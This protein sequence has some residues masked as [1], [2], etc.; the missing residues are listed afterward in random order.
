MP[1]SGVLLEELRDRGRFA[2]RLE[3][4]DLGIRQ[5]DEYDRH[6]M[7]RLRQWGSDL[8]AERIAV[9]GRCLVQILDRYGHVVQASD[10]Q[11]SPLAATGVFR[12]GSRAAPVPFS[13]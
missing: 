1:P 12:N 3:Q 11:S 6:A 2:Q 4:L 7:L 5:L 13:P 10:H 9:D 8:G